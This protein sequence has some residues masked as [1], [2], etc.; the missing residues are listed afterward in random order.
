M[1]TASVRN[2]AGGVQDALADR[3][4]SGIAALAVLGA[5]GVFMAQEIADQVLPMLD[6]PMNPSSMTDLT[7]SAMVKLVSAVV[8]AAVAVRLGDTGGAAAGTMAFGVLVSM[9]LDVVEAAQTG[10]GSAASMVTGGTT[11][12]P[13][14]A[15]SPK[16]VSRPKKTAPK[17]ATPSGSSS[18]SFR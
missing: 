4:L 18:G 14:K 9:G 16:R 6:F 17:R 5:G 2:S 7:V 15:N 1:V 3:E 10:G 13:R 12:T 8:L 11:T